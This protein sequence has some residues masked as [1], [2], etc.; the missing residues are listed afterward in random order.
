M[1]PKLK[2]PQ[3]VK[4]G[5][6]EPLPLPAGKSC[7]VALSGGPDSTMLLHWLAHE[8]RRKNFV[9]FAAHVNY[10]LRGKD[11][12]L[13]ES[14][15]RR[16]CKQLG[17]TLYVKRLRPGALTP[18][19]LQERAR[20]IRYDFFADLCSKHDIDLVATG[21]NRDDNV[22]TVLMNLGRGAGTFGL[23]GI[24][25]REGN[26]VRPLINLSRADIENYLNRNK[27]EYRTDRS[28]LESKYTRNKVRLQ[29]L[30]QMTK[31]FGASVARNIHRSAKIISDQESALREIA[32]GL[33]AADARTTAGGK[34][35]LDLDKFHLYYPMLQRIVVAL[36]FEKL[37][38]SLKDFDFSACERVL[39]A[40]AGKV[41]RVDLKAG[42]FAER[43]GQRLYIYRTS[44]PVKAITVRRSGKTKISRFWAE[45]CVNRVSRGDVSDGELKSG[46]NLRVYFDAA[47]LSGRL[48]IRSV[49]TGDKMRP[50]GM[51]GSRLL[52]DILID[53]KID[54]PLRD[55]IPVLLCGSKIAWIVGLAV[56]EDF[57]ISGTTKSVFR[58]EVKP[59]RGA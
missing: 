52:S 40:A 17:V 3:V 43:C 53:A 44:G 46:E 31:L 22:E 45:F 56:C 15:C 48:T 33:L 18:A 12:D 20:K 5:Q 6:L 42:I 28:N 37:H 4:S 51:K 19:N 27:I 47:K 7:L 49:R 41:V 21:H 25:E 29:L 34:I 35:V 9:I 2:N 14:S 36:C 30:P 58:L 24:I 54:R 55:E 32:R 23:G 26:I 1:K 13:D 59:Y 57:K 8:A 11:S 10:R 38:G 39:A 16:L 50:L